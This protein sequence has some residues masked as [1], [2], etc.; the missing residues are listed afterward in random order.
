MRFEDAYRVVEAEP[1]TATIVELWLE[2]LVVPLEYL[3]GQYVLLEDRDGDV[4]PRSYS[5]AN[6]PR[7]DGLISLLITRVHGGETSGW[8]HA[9]LRVGDEVKVSGP[10]GSFV[11]DRA[12]TAPGLFLAAG[13]G[14]APVRA[15]IEGTL[16]GGARS[17]LTLVYSARTE[18]DV[19]DRQR[20]DDLQAR[21]PR[22]RFL[23]T[24]TR[25]EGRPP[26]GRIP[27]L[28]PKL[29]RELPHHDV[30][31]AGAPGFALACAAAAEAIGAE[32]ARI[33]TELFYVEPQ[34][35]S[36]TAPVPGTAAG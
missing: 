4:P 11:D 9:H 21:D 3:S 8:V 20:F 12:A 17:S 32:R 30:F 16:A 2:P 23:R 5:I 22:F 36:G 31:I 14:L 28:L 13:S 34:P 26:N 25:D 6:A 29:F 33:H 19:I 18:R 24:L 7:P 35:W 15:L 10:Y 1:R 27:A